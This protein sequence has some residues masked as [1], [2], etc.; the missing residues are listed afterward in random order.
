MKLFENISSGYKR[1]ATGI[2]IVGFL[3]MMYL[4]VI[5]GASVAHVFGPNGG[6]LSGAFVFIKEWPQYNATTDI[7]GTYAIDQMPIGEYT[8]VG[9]GND[10]YAPNITWINVTEGNTNPHDITLSP[11]I[12]YYLPFL[13]ERTDNIYNSAVQ[14][15]NN[16]TSNASIEIDFYN[17]AGT[18]VG[19]DVFVVQ[20]GG[21][22]TKR[23]F[24]IVNGLSIFNGPSF[25]KSDKPFKVQGYILTV[26]QG[27]Y[28]LAPSLTEP[29]KQ[30]YLPFLYQRSDL[31]YD[32]GVQVF[33]PGNT[34]A[35]VEIILYYTNG[36]RAGNATYQIGPKVEASKYVFDILTGVSI[37]AGPAEII[38]DQPIVVQGYVRTK[39]SNIFSIAPSLSTTVTK[40]YLPFLYQR[41]D[42]LY[43]SGVQVY[44]P[45]STNI[46]NVN[47]N[48]Y[49]TNGT[50][51]G[52]ATYQICPKCEASKYVFD[53]VTGVSIF[54][55]PAEIISDQP[56]VVQGYIRTKAS[57]V[58]S[59]APQVRKP[60][61]AGK[62]TIPFLYSTVNVSHDAGI[63]AL[64]PNNVNA[65]IDIALYYPDGTMAGNQSYTVGP[66]VELSKYA[67][68]IAPNTV[69]FKGFAVI[70]ADQPI[71]SQGYIRKKSSN[72]FS[73][74]PPVER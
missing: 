1:I 10:S 9:A 16:G 12:K 65:T 4:A 22:F 15:Q 30:A 20:P 27:V 68:D 3:S 53:I 33:N 47:I 14:I 23:G 21:L 7:D 73:I 35:N 59:I 26:N 64:N 55:G 72:I 41:S 6:I 58:F 67:F 24:D 32:S 25:V 62:A 11:A 63:Q 51:A 69:D 46:A 13:Y 71:V 36:T 44:N 50:L 38:S 56:I 61:V 66:Y 60:D 49:Y 29:T 42:L 74:A 31:L 8:L 5:P 2:A 54:T 39:A 34:A 70:T 43:D 52:N 57:N 45:S 19:N 18:L 40:A 17:T 28:S 37:F 48:M